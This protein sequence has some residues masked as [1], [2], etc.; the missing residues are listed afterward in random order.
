MKLSSLDPEVFP[1]DSLFFGKRSKGLNKR[2]IRQLNKAIRRKNKL[3]ARLRR[4]LES[5]SVGG[6]KSK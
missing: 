1:V 2:V 5:N 6:M 3:I 4:E